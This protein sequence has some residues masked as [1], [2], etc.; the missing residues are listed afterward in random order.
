M[1]QNNFLANC[2]VNKPRVTGS[3][4]ILAVNAVILRVCFIKPISYIRHVVTGTEL[5]KDQCPA[6]VC[7]VLFTL[8]RNPC[9]NCARRSISFRLA[10][11]VRTSNKSSGSEQIGSRSGE[12]AKQ[13]DKSLSISCLPSQ[14]VGCSLLFLAMGVVF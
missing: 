4:I 13:A 1:R 2:A 7:N 12:P 5:Y 8:F 3:A 9:S 6:P 10:S 11:F 14:G